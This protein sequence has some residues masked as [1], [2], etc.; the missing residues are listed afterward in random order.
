MTSRATRTL[1]F[2]GGF[3]AGYAFTR[4]IGRQNVLYGTGA[5]MGVGLVA[6]RPGRLG[7][8]S[9]L[10]IVAGISSALVT[11]IFTKDDSPEQPAATKTV[12]WERTYVE[13]TKG[14]EAG[15]KSE[16]DLADAA[17]E[18]LR[19]K[20]Q[21]T[22]HTVRDETAQVSIDP[23]R[24]NAIRACTS[25]D[26]AACC[27]LQSA[28]GEIPPKPCVPDAAATSGYYSGYYG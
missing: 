23:A 9:S 1:G 10:A 8:T 14:C 24:T 18:Q 21:A 4:A 27:W 12:D 28:R 15:K 20:P 22:V 26:N 2:I 17:R 6:L 5:L 19:D 3:A 25:G 11:A 7:D 13:A 16:C